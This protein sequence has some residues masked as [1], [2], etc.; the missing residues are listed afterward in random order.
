M[1]PKELLFR[2]ISELD[3]FLPSR[4]ELIDITGCSNIIDGVKLL[5][6]QGVKDNCR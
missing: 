5:L 4:D 6:K 1:L 2:A 3:Y